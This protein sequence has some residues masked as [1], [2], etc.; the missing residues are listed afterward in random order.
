MN[1]HYRNPFLSQE[2]LSRAIEKTPCRKWY[3]WFNN[4]D[5]PY[6]CVCPIRDEDCIQLELNYELY[7]VAQLHKQEI[8]FK[9]ALDD[10]SLCNNEQDRLIAWVKKYTA[11]G[12]R[13]FFSPTISILSN[14]EKNDKLIIQLNPDEFSAV[15]QFQEI[16]N[17][18]YYS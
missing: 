16:F 18:V 5:V 10:Y 17:T 8:L 12:S 11:L 1:N 15:I 2:D 4:H 14:P 9:Q 13:L 6:P 3:R 7:K